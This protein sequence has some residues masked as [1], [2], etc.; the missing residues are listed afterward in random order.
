M[1]KIKYKNLSL[2]LKI[3]VITLWLILITSVI[4]AIITYLWLLK[5][6]I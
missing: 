3:A 6:L 1:E 2:P 4:P 5:L